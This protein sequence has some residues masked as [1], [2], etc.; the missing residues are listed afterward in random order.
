MI[1]QEPLDKN[2]L[3]RKTR[4]VN[5]HCPKEQHHLFSNLPDSK[6]IV[7]K[8][9]YKKFTYIFTCVR[10]T[11]FWVTRTINRDEDTIDHTNERESPGRT[12]GVWK[13][14]NG[15][16]K[17]RWRYQKIMLNCFIEI[18]ILTAKSESTR[19]DTPFT[20]SISNRHGWI[21]SST[22]FEY[23]YIYIHSIDVFIPN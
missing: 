21:S 1:D 16:G 13:Y 14:L 5:S 4:A 18:A 3:T 22:I 6:I 19:L 20:M 12:C 17:H 11:I 9:H 23:G 15:H 2:I 7:P 8:T 10:L